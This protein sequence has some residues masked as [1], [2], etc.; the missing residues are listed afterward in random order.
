M[1]RN[2][3][4]IL[5]AVVMALAAATTAHA[6]YE[7]WNGWFV[8]G[9]LYYNGYTYA[10]VGSASGSSD[11][12]TYS[13]AR[14]TFYNIHSL[15]SPAPCFVC[16][17]LDDTIYLRPD[18]LLGGKDTGQTGTKEGNGVW[19][20]TAI[21]RKNT[22]ETTWS[23]VSGTWDTGTRDDNEYFNYDTN[24]DSYL[25]G[26]DVTSSTP[27]GLPVV[28]PATAQDNRKKRRVSRPPL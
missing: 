2:K 26:W 10:E 23:A 12:S 4:L 15:S 1:G 7:T 24:P 14:D 19:S 6:Y 18:S 28:V 21:R 11:D 3:A 16:S 25:L 13:V 20:G 22:V 17:A 27:S 8:G 5:A 9:T